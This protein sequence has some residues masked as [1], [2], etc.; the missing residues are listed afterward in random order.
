MTELRYDRPVPEKEALSTA[1]REI[2]PNA[3]EPGA[4]FDS[5]LAVEVAALL[6][7]RSIVYYFRDHGPGFNCERRPRYRRAT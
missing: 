2:L 4:G 7:R 5:D 3:I 6:K 1:F